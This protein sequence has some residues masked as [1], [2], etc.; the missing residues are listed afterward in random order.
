[1][2]KYA[3]FSRVQNLNTP[4]LALLCG[5]LRQNPRWPKRDKG[6]NVGSLF[7]CSI[8]IVQCLF[9][10]FITLFGYCSGP[11]H[12]ETNHW[13]ALDPMG[14]KSLGHLMKF[15]QRIN[16]IAYTVWKR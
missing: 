6:E 7:C 15:T 9:S 4:S 5:F 14:L 12:Q 1:M 3:V 10:L 16:R 2:D 11:Q 8:G 13:L